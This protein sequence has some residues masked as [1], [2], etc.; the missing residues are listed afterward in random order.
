MSSLTEITS[1][2]LPV[3]VTRKTQAHLSA[4]GRQGLEG[5]AL[6]TGVPEGKT[7][8]IREAIIPRQ[9]GISSSE[10]LLVHV[11]GEELH[12]INLHLFRS[13]QRL[14]AQVH[15]HPR[16][17]Y[18]SSTDDEYAIA[19]ALGCLSLVVPDFAYLPFSLENCAVY[20]LSKPSWW[21]GGQG[22][23]WKRVRRA[24]ASDLIQMTE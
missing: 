4:V 12:R 22:A 13:G 9:Q 23:K 8:H 3:A 21:T 15:S 1:V 7:F 6:W 17:A 24:A 10:G 18:H 16:E 11:E 20:R 14:I 19:T 2:L 5:L